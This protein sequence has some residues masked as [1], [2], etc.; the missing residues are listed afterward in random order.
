MGR[1]LQK[2]ESRQK[3]E[4]LSHSEAETIEIGKILA[5]Q[6]T[7]G[8]ILALFGQLGSGKTVL[9]KGIC[10]GLGVPPEDVSSPS[11]TIM[12]VY[13][14]RIP[15]FHFDFYRLQPETNWTELGIDEFFYGEGLVLIEW[16]DRLGE[17]LPE[18]A[19]Q[20]F[21]QRILPVRPETQTHRRLILQG[22]DLDPAPFGAFLERQGE[23]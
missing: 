18:E 8:T 9:A 2:T 21:I 1:S 14:G 10:L 12:N 5:G 22:L 15:V 16:P 3:L 7:P 17:E 23:K 13:N 11:F 19:A 6:V 4:L 20:I